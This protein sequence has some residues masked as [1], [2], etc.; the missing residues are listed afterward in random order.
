[1]KCELDAVDV[2]ISSG[3]AY[4]DTQRMFLKSFEDFMVS[5]NCNPRKIGH[6]KTGSKVISVVRQKLSACDGAVVVAFTRYEIEKGAEFPKSKAE[7][8]IAGMK[9]PTMWNQLEGGIAYGLGVPLLI[10]A[11]RGLDRQGI[12]SDGNEWVPLEIELSAAALEEQNFTDVFVK[13]REAVQARAEARR[14]TKRALGCE[15]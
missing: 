9:I 12:L 1:M 2:F 13:W 6:I 3:S 8:A 5:N 4:T 11:E 10:L 7:K 14:G 15:T